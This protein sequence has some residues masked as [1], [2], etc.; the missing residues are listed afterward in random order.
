MSVQEVADKHVKDSSV[1]AGV[2]KKRQI[3]LCQ[4]MNESEEGREA[5]K[6]VPEHWCW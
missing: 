4:N 1:K 5:K 6:E 2:K 3:F